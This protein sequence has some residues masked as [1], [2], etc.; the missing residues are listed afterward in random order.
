M[1]KRTI[2]SH[3]LLLI[4]VPLFAFGQTLFQNLG[5]QR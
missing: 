5:G 1:R 3:V 4:L 2:T